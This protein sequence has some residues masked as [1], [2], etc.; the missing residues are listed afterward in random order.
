MWWLL[1]GVLLAI[2]ELFTGTFVL[3]MIAAGALATAAAAALGAPLL[4]QLLV[5][6][7]GTGLGLL[8]VRPA[9]RQR[10]RAAPEHVESFPVGIE[11]AEGEVLEQVDVNR[12]L[13]RI[14]GQMWSARSYDA[15]QVLA[16][17][18][19]VR[20]IEVRGATALVWR[21]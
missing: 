11:G 7:G 16:P 14:G 19:R 4:V 18:E 12:G 6:I 21:E 15:S 20:V 17:G 5:F 3:L 1:A 2:A 9:L 8:G 10:F 13:V